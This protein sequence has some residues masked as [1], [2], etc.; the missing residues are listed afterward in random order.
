MGQ[1]R[2]YDIG[3]GQQQQ[4]A[5]GNQFPDLKPSVEDYGISSMEVLMFAR[6]DIF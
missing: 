5:S 4:A 6:N 3:E 1:T 2:E